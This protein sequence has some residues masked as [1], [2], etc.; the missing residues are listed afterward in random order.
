MPA[1]DHAV[2]PV[3]VP[4]PPRSLTQL[5]C[6]TATLSEAVPP[7]ASV[8]DDTDKVALLVGDVI[9]TAGCVVS[10]NVTVS[11][12]ICVLPAAS[13]AVTVRMFA[14]VCNARLLTDQAVVP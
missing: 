4:L 12:S 5:T 9:V 11:E 2:V 14:P 8:A 3:A 1:T 7:I 6:V 13:R 10:L